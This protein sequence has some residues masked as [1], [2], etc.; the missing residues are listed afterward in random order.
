MA[1]GAGASNRVRAFYFAGAVVLAAI[2]ATACG[3]G[4]TAPSGNATITISAAGIAP[5]EVRIRRWNHVTFVNTD[6][7]PHSM[8]SDPVDVHSECPPVNRVGFL[9]PGESRDTG[10]LDLTGSCGFHDHLNQTDA[11]LRGRIIVE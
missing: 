8:V 11:G 1:D 7:R 4:P 9:Q 6:A 5:S 3:S 10:A 2:V